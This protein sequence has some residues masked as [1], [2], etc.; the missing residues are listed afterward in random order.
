DFQRFLEDRVPLE[1]KPRVP[2]ICEQILDRLAKRFPRLHQE[3][4]ASEVLRKA[5]ESL[6]QALRRRE[7]VAIERLAGG[8][9]REIR[10]NE[11]HELLETVNQASGVWVFMFAHD[12][13]YADSPGPC[14]LCYM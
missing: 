7:N 10:E 2:N 6:L 4:L 12:N 11:K 3:V 9:F 5:Q 14:V 13:L 1:E 8:H